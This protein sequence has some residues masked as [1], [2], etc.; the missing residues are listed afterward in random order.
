MLLK[1]IQQNDYVRAL[2]RHPWIIFALPLW[3]SVGNGNSSMHHVFIW[4]CE[5]Q[6][7]TQEN[8]SLGL[9]K[10]EIFLVPEDDHTSKLAGKL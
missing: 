9:V 2:S 6:E 4:E 8:K 7:E 5:K 3:S 10:A 1:L